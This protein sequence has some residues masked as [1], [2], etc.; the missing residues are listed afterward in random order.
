M[1]ACNAKDLICSQGKIEQTTFGKTTSETSNYCY[2]ETKNQLISKDCYLTH[3]EKKLSNKKYKMK[4]LYSDIG[5]PGFKLCR[6]LSGTP[7][8]INFFVDKKSYQLDRCLFKN[9]NYIDTD[10]LLSLFLER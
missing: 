9:E 2:N 1:S 8:I 10:Y 5:K 3:C 6:E 4:D 7:Q